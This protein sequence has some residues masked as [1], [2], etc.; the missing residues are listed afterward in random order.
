MSVCR[1]T[2]VAGYVEQIAFPYARED[3]YSYP[4]DCLPLWGNECHDICSFV[5]LTSLAS[6]A[7]NIWLSLSVSTALLFT[8]LQVFVAYCNW[9]GPWPSCTASRRTC[10]AWHKH[11]DSEEI[12][13]RNLSETL[14]LLGRR[15]R[16][17]V[18]KVGLGESCDCAVSVLGVTTDSLHCQVSYT[19]VQMLIFK[20]CWLLVSW[21]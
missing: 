8:T 11:E 21:G 15:T 10:M 19:N 9:T 4:E 3:T 20:R 7:L 6:G 13:S 12:W 17:K 1:S 16:L 5:P 18:K 14:A 2:S